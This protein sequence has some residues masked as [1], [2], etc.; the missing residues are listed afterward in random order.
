MNTQ[1]L[2]HNSTLDVVVSGALRRTTD[3]DYLGAAQA[4]GRCIG[5]VNRLAFSDIWASY[6][7]LH[8]ALGLPMQ[9]M[10]GMA[11][12]TS[13]LDLAASVAYI[14]RSLNTPDALTAVAAAD[15]SFRRARMSYLRDTEQS[16]YQLLLMIDNHRFDLTMVGRED[17][18][19]RV[20]QLVRVRETLATERAALGV[21]S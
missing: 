17:Q 16:E 2:S 15:R 14:L 11:P 5:H 4:A 19:G 8:D 3:V 1:I 13:K 21:R 10:G 12:S 7:A 18:S 20:A 9:W 6:D